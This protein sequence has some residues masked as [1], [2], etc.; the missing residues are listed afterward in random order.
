MTPWVQSSSKEG[1]LRSQALPHPGDPIGAEQNHWS[2]FFY[3]Y[4]PAQCSTYRGNL[5]EMRGKSSTPIPPSE[6]PTMRS[7]ALLLSPWGANRG[8]KNIFNP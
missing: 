6:E 4:I 2:A 1:V 8:L 5:A 3:A 7:T